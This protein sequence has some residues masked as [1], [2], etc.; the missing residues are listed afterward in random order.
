MFIEEGNPLLRGDLPNMRRAL[1]AGEAVRA[2]VTQIEL[3]VPVPLDTLEEEIVALLLGTAGD[4]VV[5]DE[6][7]ILRPHTRRPV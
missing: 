2:C 1:M 4:E 5:N 3:H 6:I 7:S